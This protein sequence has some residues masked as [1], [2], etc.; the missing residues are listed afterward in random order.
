MSFRSWRR[1]LTGRA[2]TRYFA[3][4]VLASVLISA[5]FFFFWKGLKPMLAG[6]DKRA[7]RIRAAL[8][9]AEA[10]RDAAEKTLADY[11][12]KQRE[13]LGE[14]EHILEHA[15]SEARRIAEQ[16]AKDLEVALKRREQLAMD[17]IAQAEAAALAAVRNQA[18]DVAV[19]ATA[20]LLRQNLDAGRANALVD[21]GLAEVARKLN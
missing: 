10:L 11:K 14:A 3:L 17:K 13:A 16:A 9:E 8:E 2:L 1:S 4:V 6:L 7:A 20:S 19:A 18:V 21:Q 5:L 12:K 15:R